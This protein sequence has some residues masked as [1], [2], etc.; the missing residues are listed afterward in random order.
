[1]F[2]CIMKGTSW[3]VHV[4]ERLVCY[5][6]FFLKGGGFVQTKTMAGF[7]G[8]RVRRFRKTFCQ[9]CLSTSRLEIAAEQHPTLCTPYETSV[10][11][12]V[13][14]GIDAGM[15][16]RRGG[17][18]FGTHFGTTKGG[19]MGSRTSNACARDTLLLYLRY[20]LGHCNW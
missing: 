10:Q 20:T 8:H 3:K 19:A 11:V 2:R 17:S 1:M 12:N 6:M 18:E 7:R 16:I 15:M 14:Q 9:C 13:S 5:L 4:M